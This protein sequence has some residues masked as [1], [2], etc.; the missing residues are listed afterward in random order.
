MGLFD[1]FKKNKKKQEKNAN[2]SDFSLVNTDDGLSVI[3][4]ALPAIDDLKRNEL[5][6]IDDSSVCSMIESIFSVVVS[7]LAVKQYGNVYG[8]RSG[9]G[10]KLYR[11]CLNSGGKLVDSKTM[12]GAKRAMVIGKNGIIEQANL[13]EAGKSIKG[14]NLLPGFEIA[15]L[16]VSVVILSYVKQI[17]NRLSYLSKYVCE[18][19]ETLEIEYKSRVQALIESVYVISKYRNEIIYQDEVRKRE[20]ANLDRLRFECQELLN[21]AELKI[22]ELIKNDCAK[23]EEYEKRIELIQKW[24]N[25]QKI[26]IRVLYQINMLDML[27]SCGYKSIEQ[28]F[29][30]FE[31]RVKNLSKTQ[32]TLKDWHKRQQGI[33]RIELKELRRKHSG[34][35]A[36]LEKPIALINNKWNFSPIKPEMAKMIDEQSLIFDTAEFCSINPFEK[37]V[38]IYLIDGKKYYLPEN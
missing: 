35:L 28:C 10:E 8:S 1:F 36:L 22:N 4:G 33:F 21:Q 13:I 27:L 11:I 18:I 15:N 29:G 9:D 17:N 7:G 5:I 31:N 12:P 26:L 16:A 30:A 37:N 32:N 6:E 14:N 24:F 2:D 20:L 23:Y 38:Q 19:V 25:Y 3:L 34:F